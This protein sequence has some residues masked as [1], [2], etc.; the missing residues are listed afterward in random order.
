MTAPADPGAHHAATGVP[1]CRR[2]K[3]AQ[4]PRDE[5]S[6]LREHREQREAAYQLSHRRVPATATAPSSPEASSSIAV[7]SAN[8]SRYSEV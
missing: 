1:T 7:S 3:Q 2:R 8:C 4:P 6:T 5:E